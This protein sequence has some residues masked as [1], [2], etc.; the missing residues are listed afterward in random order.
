MSFKEFLEEECVET[1]IDSTITEAPEFD[2]REG[3]VKYEFEEIKKVAEKLFNGK[4]AQYWDGDDDS[5]YLGTRE[6]HVEFTEDK[7]PVKIWFTLWS[8]WGHYGRAG[9]ISQKSNIYMPPDPKNSKRAEHVY[10]PKPPKGKAYNDKD[11]EGKNEKKAIQMATSHLKQVAKAIENAI[12]NS[13]F[14]DFL[15][16]KHFPNAVDKASKI[17]K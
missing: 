9:S 12:K 5:K 14:Q 8:D 15:V 4:L 2:G 1:N 13:K 17:L 10:I 6:Y 7:M 16:N 11:F 3:Y